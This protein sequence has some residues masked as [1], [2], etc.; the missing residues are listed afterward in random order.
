ME[1]FYGGRPGASFVIV[2]TFQSVNAMINAF[3]QGTAYNEVYFDEYVNIYN[4]NDR[5]NSQ[6]GNV[7]RRGYDLNNGLG[8]AQYIGN[9]TGPAGPATILEFFP[10]DEI[11]NEA[12]E[13]G[14]AVYGNDVGEDNIIE[15]NNVV[16]LIPGA[17]KDSGGQ[18]TTF[19]N[20]IIYRYCQITEPGDAQHETLN[21]VKIGFKIPYPVFKFTVTP[22]DSDDA[23]NIVPQD[24][25]NI[26]LEANQVQTNKF[27]HNWN[28][29]IPVA[30][31][32]D[33]ITKISL[34]TVN[35]STDNANVDYSHYSSVAVEQ[36]EKR[37]LDVVNHQVILTYDI[38]KYDNAN[39]ALDAKTYYISDF[40]IIKNINI[41]EQGYLVFTLPD[42]NEITS[43]VSILPKLDSLELNDYGELGFSW[44]NTDGEQKNGTFDTE[45]KWIKNIN[46]TEDGALTIIWNTKKRDSQ[47][48]V[49][50]DADG[51]P[52]RESDI[53]E[54]TGDR[55]FVTDLVIKDGIIYKH[56]SGIKSHMISIFGSA[57]G[58]I[59]D[60]ETGEINAENLLSI[61]N[62]AIHN[63]DSTFWFNQDKNLWYERLFNIKEIVTNLVEKQVQTRLQGVDIYY[64][65]GTRIDN[66]VVPGVLTIKFANNGPWYWTGEIEMTFPNKIP[67][68][69]TIFQNYAG[70]RNLLSSKKYSKSIIQS[71][72]LQSPDDSIIDILNFYFKINGQGIGQEIWNNIGSLDTIGSYN[73]SNYDNFVFGTTYYNDYKENQAE[74]IEQYQDSCAVLKALTGLNAPLTL[75]DTFGTEDSSTLVIDNNG[76]NNDYLRKAIHSCLTGKNFQLPMDG[77]A[78]APGTTR[79]NVMTAMLWT[80]QPTLDGKL[81]A[82]GKNNG[83]TS[84]K[85]FANRS[86][87]IPVYVKVSNLQF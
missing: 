82:T 41:T 2:K 78:L 87:V 80:I 31:R 29:K 84:W 65:A 9:I 47:G 86:F 32:G 38:V 39:N 22:V 46:Y 11:L 43:S 44:T 79:E 54:L 10:Y 7:Y 45:L 48:V 15:N 3:I 6:N 83:G 57:A 52:I 14:V 70:A 40:N 30:R 50:L 36:E 25:N 12:N 60:E 81:R 55:Q 35:N 76:D 4:P 28:I 24:E 37:H 74:Y 77:E 71:I 23:L 69:K 18:Y 56:Y 73:Y 62:D 13:N 21:I 63:P 64:P 5:G 75:A 58:A 67:S 66:L 53:I 49:E 17:I 16:T 68:T 61:Y 20:N 42:G 19:N 8:G 27:F 33:S 26:P 34:L 72:Y 51:N 1:S 85:E 59:V